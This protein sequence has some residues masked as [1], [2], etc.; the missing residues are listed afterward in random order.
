MAL[1]AFLPTSSA[2]H[3]RAA[4]RNEELL[5]ARSWAELDGLIRRH[6]LNAALVDPAADGSTKI[7]EVVGLLR[8]YPST[9]LVAY[10]PLSASTFKAVFELSTHGLSRV[11]VHSPRQDELRKTIELISA[12]GLTKEFLGAIEASLGRLKPVLLRAVLE[13]FDRPHRFESAADIS[14]Q[15]QTGLRDTYR[16]FYSAK[17][18]TP[19]K[20]VTIAKLLRGYAYLRHSQ[21]TIQSVSDKLGYSDARIFKEHVSTVFGCS[22][23]RLRTCERG[24]AV[25]MQLLEWFYKP[26]DK[27]QPESCKDFS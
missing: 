22:P 7:Q 12:S 14:L 9:L 13:L 2:E 20:L 10:V 4:I 5:L 8:K 18:G 17:L 11:V 19:K 3:V 26:R 16:S 23:S 1:G 27:T 21:D 6:S 24:N 25:V 15:A